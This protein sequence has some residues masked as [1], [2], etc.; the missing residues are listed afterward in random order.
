MNSSVTELKM[1]TLLPHLCQRRECGLCQKGL[2]FRIGVMRKRETNI[3][4]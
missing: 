1:Q 3:K 2:I 4:S